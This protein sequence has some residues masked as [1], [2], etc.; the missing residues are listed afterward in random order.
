MEATP[1]T[2]IVKMVYD[3]VFPF[4]ISVLISLNIWLLSQQWQEFRE[5]KHDVEELKVRVSEL[6]T[7]MQIMRE[8]DLKKKN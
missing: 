5:M 1:D 6:Q 3:K 4:V 8:F 2:N 7:T